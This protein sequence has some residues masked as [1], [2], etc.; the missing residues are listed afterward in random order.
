MTNKRQTAHF[1][2]IVL[3]S[4]FSIV[5]VGAKAQKIDK[6]NTIKLN[7]TNPMIFGGRAI[8]FNYERVL[9]NN[10]TFSI[11]LGSMGLPN[12]S[13]DNK[14]DSVKLLS[15]IKDKGF[16]ISGDYRFYLKK[17]N[18]FDAPHGVYIGPYYSFNHFSRTNGWNLNTT[19]Y[20]GNVNTALDLN[21]HSLGVELGYQFILWKKWTLDFVM[22]GPGIGHYQLRSELSTTLT[23]DQQSLFFNQLNNFLQEK[24]PGFNRVIDAGEFRKSGSGSKFGLGYRFMVNVGFRF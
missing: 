2:H 19:T 3:I 15:N 24:I 1:R 10:Q 18:K 17:E 5:L 6:K 23:L 13:K 12:F 20:N 14:G 7:I 22:I 21:V 9:K 11:G 8:V 16:H 4:L